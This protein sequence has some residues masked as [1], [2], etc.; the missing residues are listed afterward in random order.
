MK[1]CGSKEGCRPNIQQHCKT[2]NRY[3]RTSDYSPR[4]NCS[5]VCL[6]ICIRG[7]LNLIGAFYTVYIS[8]KIKI[9]K[10]QKQIKTR[11][12]KMAQWIEAPS[13]KHGN[14]SF[15]LEIHMKNG[16]S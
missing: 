14:L 8:T 1:Q 7:M 13:L 11:A 9:Q 2:G 4:H 6:S 15:L 3:L 12:G 10:N 5:C 16:D